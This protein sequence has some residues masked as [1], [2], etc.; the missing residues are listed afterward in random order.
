MKHL[1]LDV[2]KKAHRL[3]C[4]NSKGA[5]KRSDICRL[6]LQ[7]VIVALS[8]ESHFWSIL[9]YFCFF[10]WADFIGFTKK[11]T[12]AF[13][14]TVCCNSSMVIVHSVSVTA[15][16]K[17]KRKNTKILMILR[18]LMQFFCIPLI[19]KLVDIKLS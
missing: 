19:V 13:G 15:F 18:S 6:I 14:H 17:F 3:S 5:F 8:T 2:P 16:L 12:P 7:I 10:I 4:K 11:T 9:G 1:D